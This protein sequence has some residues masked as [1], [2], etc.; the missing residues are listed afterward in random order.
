MVLKGRNM[1][2]ASVF[3]VVIIIIYPSSATFSITFQNKEDLSLDTWARYSRNIS[4]A[5]EFSVCQWNK[6]SYFSSVLNTIWNYCYVKKEDSTLWCLYMAYILIPSSANRHVFLEAWIGRHYIKKEII[7]FQHRKWNH[8]CWIYSSLTRDNIL[9]LNGEILVSIKYPANMKLPIVESHTDV[10]ASALI[11]AQEQD[12]VAGGYDVEQLFSGEISEFQMWD[13]VL[14]RDIVANLSTCKNDYQGN[15][16]RWERFRWDVK[17]GVVNNDLDIN[18]FCQDYKKLVIFPIRQPL[19]KAKTICEVHGGK[20]TT[21]KSAEENLRVKQLVEKHPECVDKDVTSHKNWGTLLWLGVK[22]VNKVWYDVDK[23]NLIEELEYANWTANPTFGETDI[24]CAF[25]HPDGTWGYRRQNNGTCNYVDMCTV[26]TF[27][28]S[29]ILTMKGICETSEVDWNYFVAIDR[30][31]GKLTHYDGYKRGTIYM[32]N[33]TW[34]ISGKS[35]DISLPRNYKVAY[36]VG[37][38]PWQMFDPYCGIGEPNHQIKHYLTLSTCEFGYEYTCNSGVCIDLKGRCDGVINCLDGSDEKDCNF[39]QVPSFYGKENAPKKLKGS[40]KPMKLNT[41]IRIEYINLID[42][43]EMKMELTLQIKM[44]WKD[45]RLKVTNLPRNQTFL[46]PVKTIKELWIPLDNTIHE[47][48]TIGKIFGREKVRIVWIKSDQKS[49]A[50]NVDDPFENKPFDTESLQLGM[51]QRFRIQYICNFDLR[52]FPFD[53]QS[54]TF[55]MYMIVDRDNEITFAKMSDGITYLGPKMIH[56][57]EIGTMTSNVKNRGRKRTFEFTIQMKRNYINQVINTIFPTCLLC[58]LAFSTLFINIENFN[59]RFMGSV[60]SLLVLASLL[61]SINSGL[62]KTSYFKNIDL[63]FLWYI[64]IIFTI[65]IAH[66]I[67]DNVSVG[68]SGKFC[69]V[70]TMDPENFDSKPKKNSRRNIINK[71]IIIIIALLNIIFNVMY[72]FNSK[73]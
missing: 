14:S 12:T 32:K 8:I 10:F 58:M 42:T 60:T 36:P 48:A 68:K 40:N 27:I 57:F 3:L 2:F 67:I 69:T 22:R 41:L 55:S 18:N 70:N 56:Q 50:V 17:N 54:C 26:C 51:T 6:V 39:V 47:N 33:S 29:P 71:I 34:V 28:N 61:G 45:Y 43:T 21:P 35:H 24:D 9:Y 5:K 20:I 11:L 16:V 7:P 4:K 73:N 30:N 37:R 15:L 46:I 63:W 62:P 44:Q 65:I 31:N 23:D 1:F 13:Y 38:Y 19:L 52:N 53:S 25:M 59:N 66:V 49:L 72:F 64:T